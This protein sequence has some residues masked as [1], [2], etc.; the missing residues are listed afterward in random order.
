MIK[1]VVEG[2]FLDTNESLSISLELNNLIFGNVND[3]AKSYTYPLTLP[4]TPKNDVILEF[5]NI[6][7]NPKTWIA[8]TATVFVNG[9]LV[10]EGDLL[11]L[12]A[13]DASIS[14]SI[15]VNKKLDWLAIRKMTELTELGYVWQRLSPFRNCYLFFKVRPSIGGVVGKSVSINVSG[16][17]YTTPCV[18]NPG[19]DKGQTLRNLAALINADTARNNATAFFAEEGVG[20]NPDFVNFTVTNVSTLREFYVIPTAT[21]DETCP[22]TFEY[23]VADTNEYDTI[24]K[25][26]IDHV[27]ANPANYIYVYSE[28]LLLPQNDDLF[29]MPI[30]RHTAGVYDIIDDISVTSPQINVRKGL[31]FLL[32][33]FG[34][35]LQ[36]SFLEETALQKLYFANNHSNVPA[37][38]FGTNLPSSVNR[39][40]GFPEYFF[41][42][43]DKFPDTTL[44]SWL[45]S[46]AKLF[47]LYVDID[48]KAKV[49]KI[50][51]INNVLQNQDIKAYKTAP[52]YS[53]DKKENS[54]KKGY[55]F[56]MA[57]PKYISVYREQYE[58]F[59][60]ISYADLTIGEGANNIK[61]DINFLDVLYKNDQQVQPLQPC[62]FTGWWSS[63]PN[64]DKIPFTKTPD[65]TRQWGERGNSPK[66]NSLMFYLGFV[67][68]KPS[69]SYSYDQETLNWGVESATNNFGLYNKRW[70]KF[71]AFMTSTESVKRKIY[72]SLTDLANLDLSQ[73]VRIDNQTYFIKKLRVQLTH[74]TGVELVAECDLLVV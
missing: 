72:I 37:I 35:T 4:R 30:N 58:R 61:T 65:I 47:C 18:L 6:I 67:D 44:L 19:F 25:D 54:N 33:K 2:E 71:I 46:F 51:S 7:N 70:R 50:E 49:L 64:Y 24:T 11:L 57:K 22:Y 23:G 74:N 9:V 8:K 20:S 17:T 45:D 69:S 48:H 1:I 41:F 55:K 13:T 39:Y 62:F 42:Y 10:V 15:Q 32:A 68:G 21:W 16:Y 34:Y 53:I 31:Q 12:G 60:Q 63:L 56:T 28:L 73:K 5:P 66:A 43:K 38:N 52:T 40:F 14:A 27:M 3:L 36:S 59:N 26:W 29:H